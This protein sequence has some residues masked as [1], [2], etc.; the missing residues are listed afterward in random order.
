MLCKDKTM[1]LRFGVWRCVV[2]LGFLSQLFRTTLGG[3]QG[4]FVPR[5]L[6]PSRTVRS[7]SLRVLIRCQGAPQYCCFSIHFSPLSRP[8]SVPL[9]CPERGWLPGAFHGAVVVCFGWSRPQLC[10]GPLL[11]PPSCALRSHFTLHP[12]SPPPTLSAVRSTCV[13]VEE[14]CYP[15]R[16]LCVCV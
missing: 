10:S 7:A 15:C 4:Q 1:G 16:W 14:L 3:S 13:C 11:R 6:L 5:L 12:E 2:S 9:S 8:L